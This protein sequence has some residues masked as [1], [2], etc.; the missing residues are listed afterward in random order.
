MMWIIN[1]FFGCGFSCLPN[2][3]NQHY[4]IKQLATI[5]GLFLSAWA[6]AGLAGNQFALYVMNNYGLHVLY[7]CLGVFYA[8]ELAILLVWV[9]IAAKPGKTKF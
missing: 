8:A 4:G 3:L 7:I 6:A 9:R 5:H 1:F 2:I